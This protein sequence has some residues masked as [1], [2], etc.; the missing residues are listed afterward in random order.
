M[1]TPGQARRDNDDAKA[2][3]READSACALDFLTRP[4]HGERCVCT[5]PC[6]RDYD[7]MP[8]P[9]AEPHPLRDYEGT[10][11]GALYGGPMRP[12]QVAALAGWSLPRPTDRRLQLEGWDYEP[13][14]EPE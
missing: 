12:D 14:S 10:G 11:I 8:Y 4:D 2:R 3:A 9:E 7:P 5:P 13:G 1:L 6:S